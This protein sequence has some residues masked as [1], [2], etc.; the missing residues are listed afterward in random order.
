MSSP[1]SASGDSALGD[2]IGRVPSTESLLASIIDYP[3]EHGRTYHNYKGVKYPFPNDEDEMDRLDLQHHI[4]SLLFRGNL[5]L[6]P[7]SPEPQHI[8][9]IGTGSGIW[10]IEMA[11]RYPFTCVLG[12][13]ISA[14]QPEWVP[15]N[16]I[17][18]VDDA[19]QN[20]TFRELFDLIHGR[21][22]RMGVD[23]K[24][25]FRQSH[26]HLKEGGWLEIKEFALPLCCDD[27]TLDGTA[28]AQWGDDMM[29]ASKALE[30]PFDNPHD[31]RQWM[32]EAG[33]DR[34]EEFVYHIPLNKWSNPKKRTLGTWQ[35]TNFLE[36]IQGLSLALLTKH[37]NYSRES[38]EAFLVQVRKDI[39]NPEIHGYWELVC[40]IGQ[41]PGSGGGSGTVPQ[42]EPTSVAP[43][44]G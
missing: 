17:F 12:T 15:P 1:G 2:C 3:E 11:E 26:E 23:K 19:N 31:Y 24:K 34:V 4:F 32:E 42:S 40:V 30:A 29:E 41:R 7:I 5:F 16:C 37:L 20:W 22:L 33:F 6:A 36:G 27:N 8:L 21:Y 9:D 25:F 44:H 38:L 43:E 13:D 18:Q 39:R 28:L 10:A 35:M 14:T